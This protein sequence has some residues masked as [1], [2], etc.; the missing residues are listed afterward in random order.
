MN[1]KIREVMTDSIEV[2]AP[3]ST[4]E[5]AAQKMS[6][7][8]I[9]ALPVCDSD[10]LI[11]MLTDRDIAL[12]VVAEGRDGKTPVRD[13]MTSP[14]VYVFEDSTVDEATRLMEFKQ[15]RRLVVLNREKRLAGIV[16]LGDI[17]V[18]AGRGLAGEALER[19]SSDDA[20]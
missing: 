15:I 8:G 7:L 20:A 1:Q 14:I 17:A 18:K 11:G 19:I 4:T 3:E 13:A 2:I 16:A 12:R 6:Q 5:E 9:G 10:R